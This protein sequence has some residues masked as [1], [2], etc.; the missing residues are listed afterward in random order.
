MEPFYEMALA[1]IEASPVPAEYRNRNA[2][3]LVHAFQ[4]RGL[5]FEPILRAQSDCRWDRGSDCIVCL[6]GCPRNAKQSTLVQGIPQAVAE[7]LIVE[8]EF[9]VQQLVHTNEDVRL[10]GLCRGDHRE[11]R[12]AKVVL[13]GGSFGTTQILLRSTEIARRLPALGKAFTSHPQFMNYG[14]HREPVD[15]QKGPFSAVESHDPQLRSEGIKLENVFAAPIATAMLLPGW[16]RPHH[17]LLR[18]YRSLACLE[19]AIQDEAAGQLYLDR[20]RQLVREKPLTRQDRRRIAGGRK[21][22]L[23]LLATAGA[24]RVL[25]C[26]M[27]FGLH[28]MGGCAIGTDPA[29][30]VVDPQFR[31]H[32]HPNLFVADSSIFPSAPGINPS[33]TIM[34]LSL[35][36]SQSMLVG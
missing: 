23:D 29:R 19:F 4:R 8:T 26:P 15:A 7:G 22:A 6:G 25:A 36:A 9:E 18:K 21:L 24:D 12:A 16:G 20:R 11:V 17:A 31:V 1:R 2:E 30:S 28:L 3:L 27:A 32:R 10:V 14:L 34:A 35:R 33:L 5:E 13:A